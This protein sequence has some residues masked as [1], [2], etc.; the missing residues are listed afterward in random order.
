MRLCTGFF[1][2]AKS[3]TR[4]QEHFRCSNY[5]SGRGNC[6]VHYIRDVVLERIVL[7]AISEF[8]DFVKCHEAVFL[9]WRCR[10][11]SRRFFAGGCAA[12]GLS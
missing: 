6:S 4:N 8:A 1:S 10:M 2:A 7:E 12:R 3:L 11:G 9:S 5:K